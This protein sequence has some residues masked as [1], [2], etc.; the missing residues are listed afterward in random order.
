MRHH[1]DPEHAHQ[2]DSVIRKALDEVGATERLDI[3]VLQPVEIR[4]YVFSIVPHAPC[5][6]GVHIHL[7]CDSQLDVTIGESSKFEIHGTKDYAL[8]RL[9]EVVSAVGMGQFCETVWFGKEQVVCKAKGEV[10]IGSNVLRI[11][12]RSPYPL[13]IFGRSRIDF[14]YCKY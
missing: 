10:K 2:V 11:R 6:A 7:E 12:Y 1:D 3:E 5:G 9:G 8:Q 14:E 4:G 13:P